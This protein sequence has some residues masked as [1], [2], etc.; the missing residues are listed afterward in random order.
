MIINRNNAIRVACTGGCVYWIMICLS[1]FTDIV[2]RAGPK[3]GAL[4]P[5]LIVSTF[6]GAAFYLMI[7]WTLLRSGAGSRALSPW[8]WTDVILGFSPLPVILFWAVV[9][10]REMAKN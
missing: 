3:E 5:M 8:S 1:L 6:S 2:T 4:G 9:V 10:I 7:I